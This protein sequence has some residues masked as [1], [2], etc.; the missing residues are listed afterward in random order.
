MVETSY[1]RRAARVLLLL[2]ALLTCV[3]AE[4]TERVRLGSDSWPPFT[5][6]ADGNRLALDLVHEALRRAGVEAATEIVEWGAVTSGLRDGSFD[7]SAAIWRSDERERALVF[8]EPYLENRLVLVGAKGSEVRARALYELTGK[9]VGVV[10]QYAYGEE[11]DAATGPHFVEGRSD[12]QNLE[13]LLAA[14]LDY[15]LVDELLIRHLAARHRAETERRLEIGTNA[16]V[17]RSLHFALRRELEGAEAIVERFETEI[18]RMLAD[19]TY[20]E[21]LRLDWIRADVDGDGRLELVPR[22]DRAGDEEPL[23][24][25]SVL[26]ETARESPVSALNRYW[27]DGRVYEDWESVPERYKTPPKQTEPPPPAFLRF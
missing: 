8:S 2:P 26:S 22:D 4:A 6:S 24:S 20:N 21:V 27:I 5:D 15:I 16:L 11:V 25:Y 23:T 1:A 19:G 18:R 17:T 14:E 9:R 13:R 3:A 7:G 10:A 12:Q